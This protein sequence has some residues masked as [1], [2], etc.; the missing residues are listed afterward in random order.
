MFEQ[1]WED[2]R[3]AAGIR[4]FCRA[5]EASSVPGEEPDP[6]VAFG[7]ALADS[8]DPIVHGRRLNA[9]EIRDPGR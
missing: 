3:K 7:L 6:W 4:E 8:L 9:G 1:A 2:W 5:L